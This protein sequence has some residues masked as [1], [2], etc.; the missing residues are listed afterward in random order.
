MVKAREHELAVMAQM[1]VT[2]TW[3][4]GYEEPIDKLGVGATQEQRPIDCIVLS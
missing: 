2:D 3:S 1:G 4:Q